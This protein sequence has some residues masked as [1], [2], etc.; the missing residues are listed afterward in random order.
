MS[1]KGEEGRGSRMRRYGEGGGKVGVKNKKIKDGRD[2]EN[3]KRI[4]T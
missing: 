3:D 2:K 1:W 4:K